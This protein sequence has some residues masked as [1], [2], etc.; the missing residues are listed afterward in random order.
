M[1]RHRAVRAIREAQATAVSESSAI[2]VGAG[3]AGLVAA[4]AV[5]PSY[6]H[7][8]VLERDDMDLGPAR[9]RGVPQSG[10][11]H[12]LLSR[13]L[14]SL[15]G[16]APGFSEALVAAGGTISSVAE[17]THVWELGRRMPERPLGLRLGCAARPTIDHVLRS[18]VLKL[19]PNVS[20]RAAVAASGLV[21]VDGRV[22]GV[23]IQG[24]SIGGSL[25]VDATGPSGL[26]SQW[27]RDAGL[28]VPEEQHAVV[29][30]WYATARFA[31]P[32]RRHGDQQFWMCFPMPP[33]TL[34]GL[35]SPQGSDEWYVS[36]SGGGADPIPR[37]IDGLLR[38]VRAL[39]DPSIGELLADATPLGEPTIFRRFEA[40][41]RHFEQLPQLTSGYIAI[42]DAL[43]TLNPLFGQGMSVAAWEATAL[44][45]ISK[46]TSDPDAVAV[47]YAD[48]AARAVEAAWALG[49]LVAPT[50]EGGPGQDYT[51]ALARLL[52][53]DA[54]L[55]RLY[56]SVWHLLEPASALEAPHIASRVR[57]AL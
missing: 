20:I 43:A 8:V 46:Q 37:D 47:R 16:L 24:E 9:R 39:E 27:L 29:D 35:V 21:V 40:R 10:Q 12:N 28:P 6:D 11:L 55:H 52:D 51:R 42:G 3:F 23:L 19:Y 18:R 7:V 32:A 14:V 5:A 57:A 48:E 1:G 36:V 13:A 34:G 17:A 25:V 50:G 44:A 41:W 31:R 54:E 49:G 38:H 53:D 26:T 33:G 45:E 2:V 22:G 15:E 30:Q 56:V 4:A